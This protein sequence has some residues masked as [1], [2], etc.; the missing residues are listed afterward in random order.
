VSIR[1]A[2]GECVGCGAC[3]AVCPGSLISVAGGKARIQRPER[4]WGCVACVKECPEQ[5][6]EFYLGEDMGGLGGALTVR[7]E[8]S[9]LYWTV[10]MPDGTATTI[11]VDGADANKY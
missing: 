11:A 7:R 8:S 1:I 6:I 10:A 4:C 2:G 9:I 3:A 5:A